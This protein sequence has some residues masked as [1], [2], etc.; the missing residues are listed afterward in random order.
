MHWTTTT[1][2]T[3]ERRPRNGPHASKRKAWSGL[4]GLYI[5]RPL[6]RRLGLVRGC[7]CFYCCCSCSVIYD[8]VLTLLNEKQCRESK[9]R[10][11]KKK[12]F[13]WLSF[14]SHFL[15]IL[16]FISLD[17][18]KKKTYFLKFWKSYWD[19]ICNCVQWRS[20][21]IVCSNKMTSDEDEDEEL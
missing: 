19:L 12:T 5:G 9:K 7:Y 14:L 11:K 10:K 3:A 15:L 2:T 4:N 6:S 8:V 16:F 17:F 18:K 20:N 21:V 1:T 13:L